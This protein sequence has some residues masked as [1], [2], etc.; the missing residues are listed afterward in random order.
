MNLLVISL[1][2]IFV[3]LGVLVFFMKRKSNFKTVR[4]WGSCGCDEDSARSVRADL[5]G[6]VADCDGVDVVLERDPGDVVREEKAQ[7][8]TL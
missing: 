7:Q 6:G 2:V 1:I 5:H 8:F 4:Q 3:I